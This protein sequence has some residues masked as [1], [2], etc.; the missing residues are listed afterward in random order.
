MFASPYASLR[1]PLRLARIG[2]FFRC[3][4]GLLGAVNEAWKMYPIGFLFGLGFDTATEV[5]LLGMTAMGNNL[6]IPPFTIM[7]LPSLFAAAM[8]LIDTLDGLLMLWTYSW[9]QLDPKKRIFFNLYLT[10]MSAAI[11]I[12]VACIEILGRVQDSFELE[13]NQFWLGI[14]N[15][16]DNFE[17]VGY[18]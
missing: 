6:S 15:V 1:A 4:P 3:C 18:R 9:A 13:G 16:N 12:I 7:I 5:A 2:F 11:A 14:K 10:V 8:T 17:F